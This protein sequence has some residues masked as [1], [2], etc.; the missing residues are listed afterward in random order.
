MIVCPCHERS[1]HSGVTFVTENDGDRV[2]SGAGRVLK[3]AN[4]T[5]V[6]SVSDSVDP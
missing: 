6:G 4:D 5:E 3:R 1:P 2:A